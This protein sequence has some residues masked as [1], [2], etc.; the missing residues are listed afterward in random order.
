MF[1]DEAPLM[2]MS[3]ASIADLNGR[4]SQPG[5]CVRNFRPNILVT[6]CAAFSEVCPFLHL[7]LDKPKINM[8]IA[9]SIMINIKDK[10][11]YFS[12]NDSELRAIEPT[13]R[14]LTHNALRVSQNAIQF[15]SAYLF[16]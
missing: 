5:V 4:L 15:L 8:C 10:W 14:Y 16:I 7:L 6:D 1:A 9:N 11:P 2:L 13:P 3:E 12:I